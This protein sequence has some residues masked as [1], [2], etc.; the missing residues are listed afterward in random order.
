MGES[1]R[2]KKRKVE[3][4]E[5]FDWG[6]LR[7]MR[8]GKLTVLQNRMTKVQ[9]QEFID[10]AASLYQDGCREIDA[11]VQ[12][13]ATS[14][15]RLDP[16]AI[17]HRAYWEYLPTAMGIKSEV[18]V[19]K[20]G[21]A[22]RFVIEYLQSMVCAVAP[23]ERRTDKLIEEEWAALTTEITGLFDKITPNYFITHTAWAL[24]N[25]PT[26]DER[27]EEFS[28]QAQMHWIAVR[29]DRYL[30]HDLPHFQDLLSPHDEEFKR[31]FGVSSGTVVGGIGRLIASFSRG[32][33]EAFV[34]LKDFQT[35]TLDA[36]EHYVD[37]TGESGEPSELI[38]KVIRQNG[39]EEWRDKVLDNALGYGLFDAGAIT[40]WPER[41]LDCLSWQPGEDYEF[42]SP[43]TFCGWP[44]RVLPIW[45]RPFLKIAGR[46]YSFGIYPL[47]DHGYRI[48]QRL[49]VTL[50]PPYK[51]AWNVRQ[52]EV[53]ENLPLA[54]LQRLLPRSTVYRSV[55]YQWATDQAGAKQWYETDGVL[56]YDD[57]LIVVE[58]KAGAFTYTPPSTDFPAYIASLDSLIRKPSEQSSRFCTYLAS[59]PT[60]TLFDS[61][62]RPIGMLERAHFRSITRC[63]VTLDQLTEFAA[64][65]ENLHELGI[66]VGA[67]PVWTISVDDLRVIAD[68]I[69]NPLV[70]C[71]FLEQR[72]KAF[73][74]PAL[75]TDDE[76]DHLALY[77]SHNHYSTY[78]EDFKFDNPLR[79]HGYRKELDEYFSA[80]ISGE[81]VA[82][83]KQAIPL[84]LKE[85]VEV[86]A[87]SDIP[88]RCKAA[89]W[90]LD[91]GGE[92]RNQA[93]TL[94]EEVLQAQQEVGRPKPATCMGEI[95][96]TFYCSIDGGVRAD[97]E[98]LK[99]HTLATM[100]LANEP[101]R[102]AL[103]LEYLPD[104]QLRIAVPSFFSQDDIGTVNASELEGYTETL[105]AKRFRAHVRK[106]GRNKIGRNERCPCGSGK[107]YKHCCGSNS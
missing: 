37:T 27:R 13:I 70:F 102:L 52:K 58:V 88:G 99:I 76:I 74:S 6:P 87:R 7:M 9:H 4:D 22:K 26:Y 92:F 90:I 29:G 62:H 18:E 25:D 105:V 2:K 101:E 5:G 21:L 53:S 73:S 106:A 77:L 80:K 50:D 107:K 48:F 54:L 79:W 96:V 3:A 95:P 71:H 100:Q 43:G 98:L 10:R 16:L 15:S 31:L 24:R 1:M 78:A 33:F 17:L 61:Q 30:C 84:R 60:V 64:R 51:E 38:D 85:I 49:L 86:L 75:Q 93:A 81:P 72:A 23:M 19:G 69:D 91:M 14:V 42:L 44:L 35:K 20:E 59:E 67:A 39:W 11:A 97:D 32:P 12:R 56:V 63:C 82:L 83:P 8:F 57:H 40:G 89:A 103:R 47:T 94:I 34:A 65:S 36:L 104:Q 46:Y 28:V 45:K 55:H 68:V 66:N 41:L